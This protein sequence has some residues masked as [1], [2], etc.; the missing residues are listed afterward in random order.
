ME[1]YFENLNTAL[2]SESIAMLQS[3]LT[4]EYSG[5]HATDHRE[6]NQIA[7]GPFGANVP[8][9]FFIELTESRDKTESPP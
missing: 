6:C 2:A 8:D 7:T 5:R 4:T 3:N 9:G 1:R